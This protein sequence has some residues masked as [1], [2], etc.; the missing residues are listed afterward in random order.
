MRDEGHRQSGLR[1]GA[2]A[3]AVVLLGGCT[4]FPS[5]EPEPSTEPQGDATATVVADDAV[6]VGDCIDTPGGQGSDVTVLPCDGPH[7][8]EAFA[9]TEMPDGEYPGLPAAISSATEFCAREFD[10]F[11]G[12]DYDASALEM[13]YFYP[14]EDSWTTAGDRRILCLVAEEGQTPVTGSLEGT[15][16]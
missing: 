13:L 10:I 2:A 16:R 8:F 5:T 12:V 1:A 6:D 11:V 9:A 15:A 3:A 14:V 7:I 4:L